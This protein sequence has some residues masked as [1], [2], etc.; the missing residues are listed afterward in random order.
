MIDLRLLKLFAAAPA[1][2][3]GARP[4]RRDRALLA[5]FACW[6]VAA[7]AIITSA[8]P[9]RDAVALLA[10]LALGAP[11]AFAAARADAPFRAHAAFQLHGALFIGV[12]AA[13][14]GGASSP[15]FLWAAVYI[16]FAAIAGRGA[17]LATAGQ[18]AAFAIAWQAGGAPAASGW[19]PAFLATAL[20][21]GAA[22]T[23]MILRRVAAF[24]RDLKS[25]G[26]L[27]RTLEAA[28]DFTARH[29]G[30]GRVARLTGALAELTGH[31]ASVI[32]GQ[33][34]L[35]LAHP[36][37]RAR[38]RAAFAEAVCRGRDAEADFRLRL[39]DGGWRWFECRCRPLARNGAL[40]ALSGERGVVISAYRD[41]DA[42]KRREAELAAER[43]R[44]R[45]ANAAKS[46]F[47]A[48]MS[49]ELR[50]PLNAMIGFAD[51][52]REEMFGPMGDEK[53][54]EYAELIG[55]SGRHLV[56]VIGDVLDLSK[57]EARKYAL[58]IARVDLAAIVDSAMKIVGPQ[59]RAAQVTVTGQIDRNLP[60]LEADARAIKQ[61]LLNLLANALKFT[62]AGGRVTIV[63]RAEG[64]FVELSICDTGVGIAREDLARLVRPFEQAG[65]AASR[66]LGAGLGLALV[67]SLANLHG[68]AFEIESEPGLGTIARISLP[69]RA[70]RAA[71]VQEVGEE[72]SEEFEALWESRPARAARIA[73]RARRP[74]PAASDAERGQDVHEQ[75]ARV[76]AFSDAHAVARQSDPERAP[77]GVRGAA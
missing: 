15:A 1:E 42:R 61:M 62:P 73:A 59:A 4:N 3:A 51:M 49:H 71:P 8:A 72:A 26:A 46:R 25:T 18:I 57:I 68:G 36:E 13:A 54:H 60:A 66:E 28:A 44:E 55:D 65:D 27:G 23:L 40:A 24:D 6:A 22:A 70:P 48:N 34:I 32:E 21:A 16:L 31:D 2:F 69:R 67:R 12:A 45:E 41:I 33:S 63:A 29:D 52:M 64:E 9:F 39:R 20:F 56:A 30:D 43:D 47:L 7:G 58:D 5:L 14:T 76:R 11:L 77:G 38:L 35:L 10:M 75:L 37:D 19:G 50:T 53:Y 17:A 74:K